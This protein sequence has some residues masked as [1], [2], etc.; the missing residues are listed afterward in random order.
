MMRGSDS[1]E[2]VVYE[3]FQ[4]ELTACFSNQEELEKILKDELYWKKNEKGDEWGRV[5]G[6]VDPEVIYDKEAG[7]FTLIIH[8]FPPTG[9]CGRSYLTITVPKVREGPQTFKSG[10]IHHKMNRSDFQKQQKSK[11]IKG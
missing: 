6:P 8:N 2:E 9:R 3:E 5:G 4:E 7:E 1:E 10:D 11:N